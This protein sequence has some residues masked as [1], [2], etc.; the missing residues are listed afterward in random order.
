[1]QSTRLRHRLS[2]VLTPEENLRSEAIEVHEEG[3]G[4]CLRPLKSSLQISP[5]V[6]APGVHV[7][8]AY[9]DEDGKL[10]E[11]ALDFSQKNCM[12]LRDLQ[13]MGG[14]DLRVDESLRLLLLEAMVQYPAQS[15]NP[16]YNGTAYPDDYCKFFLPGLHRVRPKGALR[17][18]NKIGQA[19][20]FTVDNSYIMDIETGRNFFLSAVLYTNANGILND[21]KYEYDV[22][23]RVFAD[24]AEVLA[25]AIWRTT[26]SENA[27]R[28]HSWLPSASPSSK[29]FLQNDTFVEK[30]EVLDLAWHQ[31]GDTRVDVVDKDLPDSISEEILVRVTSKVQI[32]AKL[33]VGDTITSRATP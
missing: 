20:G 7:G 8:K 9:L 14:A 24:L 26:F 22:A 29:S 21:D 1:M 30:E 2:L 6:D 18:Y 12:S 32:V 10:V 3:G 5:S 4:F 27:V 31:C 11:E 15:R 13:N 28:P 19:Y 16:L 23:Y 17:V 25:R 33:E